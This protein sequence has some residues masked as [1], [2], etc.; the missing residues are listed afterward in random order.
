MA[1]GP[2]IS[3]LLNL[4]VSSQN[5]NLYWQDE[6]SPGWFMFGVWSIYLVCLVYGFTDPPRRHHIQPPSSESGE[7]QALL[8]D[9]SS[10]SIDAKQPSFWDNIPTFVTFVVYFVSAM[11]FP[12]S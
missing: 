6:N 8:A 10:S 11:D 1:A 9:R 12:R 3:S 4:T 5:Q 2:A 7:K